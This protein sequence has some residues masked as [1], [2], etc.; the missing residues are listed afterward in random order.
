M[1]ETERGEDETTDTVEAGSDGETLELN[2]VSLRLL[3]KMLYDIFKQDV[4]LE[5]ERLGR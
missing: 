5:R 2:D 1:A 4:R 3:T